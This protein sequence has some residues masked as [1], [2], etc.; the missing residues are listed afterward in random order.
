MDEK[1]I[2]D[3]LRKQEQAIADVSAR[4][5]ERLDRKHPMAEVANESG[6]WMREHPDDAWRLVRFYINGLWFD[7]KAKFRRKK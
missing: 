1:S 4:L 2:V 6:A 5:H 3:N 7:I